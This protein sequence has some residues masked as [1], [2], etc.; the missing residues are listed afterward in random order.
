MLVIKVN[1]LILKERVL[2]SAFLPMSL[3]LAPTG[4]PLLGGAC[5]VT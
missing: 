4:F 1:L 5:I 2:L 3:S